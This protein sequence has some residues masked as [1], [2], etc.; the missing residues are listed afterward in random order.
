MGRVLGS[1]RKD[2]VLATK[3]G[4]PMDGAGKTGG[5]SR[6]YVMQAVEASLRRLQTDWIDLYQLHRPDPATPIEETLRALDDLVKAGKVRFIGCS[7][8][9]AAQ[10]ERSVGGV[11]AARSCVLHHLS[12]RI[13]SAR[14]RRRK[15][16][17]A[18]DARARLEAAAVFSAG[19][20]IA[21]RKIQTATHRCR[22]ARG[23]PA[24]PPRGNDDSTSATGASSKRWREFAAQ[25]GHTLLELAMSWLASRPYIPS[26]IAGATKP[27]QVEAQ[28]RRRRLGALGRRPGRDRPHNTLM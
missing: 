8:F 2:I 14:S 1:R 16:S 15:R 3:F 19:E 24:A 22:Q 26:I 17:P 12:G 7:N 28:C 5:A 11:A 23:L 13:Q 18:G 27:E 9:S 4:L 6:R 25:R 20:R 10:L 21:D